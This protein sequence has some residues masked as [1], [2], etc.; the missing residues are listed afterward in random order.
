MRAVRDG[1]LAVGAALITSAALA[2][3]PSLATYQGA[4]RLER[5]IE[6]AK[7]EGELTIYTSTP[8]EDMK[9]LTDAFERKYNVKT[10]VWRAS[11][12]KVVQRG[13]VE[14]RANRFDVDVFET[15]EQ[16]FRDA[17]AQALAA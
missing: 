5:L 15:T 9:V 13:V 16:L 11:S 7:R 10:K 2:D 1:A 14:A 4:D 6:A 17:R 12:E 3:G 8:V